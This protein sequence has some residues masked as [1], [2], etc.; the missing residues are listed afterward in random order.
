M[1]LD[2]KNKHAIVCGST[3][4]IG[5]ST[6]IKLAEM[7]ANITL[8][9]RNEDKLKETIKDLPSGEGQNHT[10]LVADFSK[11][12]ELKEIID[13]Y[14]VDG[15]K[16]NILVNRFPWKKCK[17]LKNNRAVWARPGHQNFVH[18]HTASTWKFQTRGHAHAGCFST[19]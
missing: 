4:G 14:F 7:G 17:L 6:A 16:V 8:I 12:S 10:Y 1:N 19:T 9:A 13:K 18:L 5:K 2:L 15:N 11:P 3:Q